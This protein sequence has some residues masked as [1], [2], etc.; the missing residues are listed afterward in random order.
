MLDTA[1]LGTLMGEERAAMPRHR[2]LV[3]AKGGL[4][5]TDL[6]RGGGDEQARS[7]L[8]ASRG[9]VDRVLKRRAQ[10][11]RA[12]VAAKARPDEDPQ[13]SVVGMDV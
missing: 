10:R 9:Q 5:A 3:A 11:G 7:R 1:A 4:E 12:C 8:D 2:P 13:G 6:P